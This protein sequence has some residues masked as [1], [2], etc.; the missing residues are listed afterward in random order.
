[1]ERRLLIPV[2]L[3]IVGW[4]IYLLGPVLTPFLVSALLAY[5]GDPLVDRLE[6]WHLPRSFAVTLVFVFTLA[7][8]ALVLLVLIP[9]L[10]QEV[11]ALLARIPAYIKWAEEHVLPWL[12]ARLHVSAADIDATR[13][14]RLVSQ[15]LGSAAGLA[16]GTLG[17]VTR[18]GGTLVAWISNLVLVPV[19]T[20]YL[21]RDWDV[22][23]ARIRD[24]LPRRIEP[25]ISRLARGCD[26]VLGAFF[27]GQ[28][29][30]M[31]SLA[32]VYAGGLSLAGLNN[33]VAIGVVAG[34][35]SFV[36]Y[37]GVIIGLSLA[38]LTGLI[39][40]DGWLLL[41][42]VLAV[43]AIGQLLES[44]VLTPRLVGERIGLHPVVVI[45]ALMAGGQLFGFSGVLLAL[46]AAAAI[47][48]VLR[49]AHER[50]RMSE[51]YQDRG[52]A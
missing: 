14:S 50:Y 17:S 49:Y 19:V 26:E 9:A 25:V 6:S 39:Q 20:F 33:A 12:T 23:M 34:L 21:L 15:Y 28:L 41:G 10:T 1:M 22:L 52:E 42:W 2:A 36:P 27:R 29:L 4:L 5:M 43:F 51:V 13:L 37:L 46:P 48:V 30:V 8:V 47:M 3:L 38:L 11:S 35:V 18:S 24:L 40:G 7:L 44:F 32:V 31:V 45:F 16:A